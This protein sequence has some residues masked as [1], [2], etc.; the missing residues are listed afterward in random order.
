MEEINLEQI[1]NN[2]LYYNKCLL[3]LD[4]IQKQCIIDIMQEA[5]KQS[6]DMAVNKC[7]YVIDNYGDFGEGI[8]N[9][10]IEQVK[11][12]SKDYIK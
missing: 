7:K 5:S 4:K 9:D 10:T 3:E 12:M 6:W 8:K 2:K 1:F 11:E